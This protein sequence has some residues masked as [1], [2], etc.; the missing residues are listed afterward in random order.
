MPSEREEITIPDD[1]RLLGALLAP[2][3][4]IDSTFLRNFRRRHL[5][6]TDTGLEA[7]FWHSDLVEISGASMIQLDWEQLE[8]LGQKAYEASPE[9]FEQ[10]WQTIRELHR[11]LPENLQLQE[12][13]RYATITGGSIENLIA[14][15]HKT[16]AELEQ[17]EQR[18]SLGRWL[19]AA[20]PELSDQ[21]RDDKLVQWLS[22][23]ARAELG[24]APPR[25]TQEEYERA[26]DLPDWL[27]P[28]RETPIM[29]HLIGLQ[30]TPGLIRVVEPSLSLAKLAME[31]NKPTLLRAVWNVGNER[32]GGWLQTRL[33]AELVIDPA[34]RR[35]E[36]L[37]PDGRRFNLLALR[38]DGPPEPESQYLLLYH[39]EDRKLAETLQGLLREREIGLEL[40]EESESQRERD[41]S[42][43]PVICLWT[44]NAASYWQEPANESTTIPPGLL[45]RTDRSVSPPA[46][47][48]P[49]DIFDLLDLEDTRNLEQASDRIKGLKQPPSS[50]NAGYEPEIKKLLD[51]IDNP[52]TTPQRRLEIGDQLAQLD[53]PRPGV[54]VYEA[55]IGMEIES[56]EPEERLPPEFQNLLDQIENSE[57]APERRLDIGDELASLSDPRPGVGL[58]EQG[59]PDIDWV[60]IPGGEFIYGENESQQRLT[61]DSYFIARYP[62]TN[63]QYQS[64]IDDGGYEE[65]HWWRGLKRQSSPMESHWNQPNRP[66]ESVSWYEAAAFCRWLSQQLGYEIH[67]PTEQQW[68]KAARGTD[69]REYPWGNGF[70]EGFANVK[71]KEKKAGPSYLGQTTAVGLYPQGASPY[72]VMDMAGNVWEW[73]LNKYDDLEDT[74]I[75]E[76]GV[77]RM[78]RGG[79]WV[80]NSEN[81]RSASCNGFQPVIRFNHCGF[82]VVC[83]SPILR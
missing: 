45:L 32:Q 47:S 3:V 4:Q 34:C 71:E 56:Q 48:G 27:F 67:L 74:A 31:S 18:R 19:K 33:G 2:A 63:A 9:R 78:L 70:R 25:L 23:L 72:G 41:F 53:D 30:L 21:V 36:I 44:R 65:E 17:P 50:P 55:E 69:G 39:P 11:S 54:G 37:V 8:G 62:I 5:P 13:L 68:E 7:R 16:F 12:A 40:R 1:I 61:L 57:T 46:G 60:E 22:V 15:I 52:N 59:L 6:H 20:I 64:F 80:Y 35:V 58:D 28:E 38:E 42:D 82:R 26:A 10:A 77:I 24:D 29:P 81:A 76:T 43:R 49:A 73:C 75:Y 83:A 79:A 14:R 66:R 51:E